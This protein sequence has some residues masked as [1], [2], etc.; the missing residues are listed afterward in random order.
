MP[1]N[2]PAEPAPSGAESTTE[3]ATN[4][5]QN[6]ASTSAST[7][8]DFEPS[9][10]TALDNAFAADE[11]G[12]TEEA[13]KEDAKPAEE[14]SEDSE[15]KPEDSSDESG[16]DEAVKNMTASAGAKFKEIKAE[17]KAA[18]ARVAELEAKLS[19]VENAP[20]PD[21]VEA[22]KLQAAIAEKEAKL[23]EYEKEIAI[24]RFE[25]TDEYKESVVAPMA[26]I[27]GVVEDLAK[28]YEV[29]E[30]S[31]LNILEEPN[32][33]TQEKMILELASNFSERDRITLYNLGDDYAAVIEQRDKLRSRASEALAVREKAKQAEE[34][35]K[36]EES[37]KAWQTSAKSVW[38]SF[39]TKVPLPESEADRGKFES[40]VV[41]QVAKLDFDRLSN[42]HKAFA[43][44]AGAVIPEVV[45]ANKALASE[46]SELKAALQ[47]YQSATPGAGTG[48]ETKPQEIDTSLS[49][50][51]ALE[52]R[53]AA[54]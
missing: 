51:D 28:E 4:T 9:W 25:A 20:K 38:D 42:D 11:S 3:A 36:V 8:G 22:E 17:A 7:S 52:K 49:F 21:L 41:A 35:R 30:K 5:P 39:K 29:S 33:K 16:D 48:T 44:Y 19:E 13:K 2:T 34:A 23:A 31:L 50:L 14:K 45:K 24:S 47:K 46:V 18:R 54:S 40:E 26:A 12:T 1:D 37:R 53:L 32:R 43:A 15:K 27:I 6:D 10:F